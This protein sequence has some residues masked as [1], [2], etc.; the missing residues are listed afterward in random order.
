M[1]DVLFFSDQAPVAWV[2]TN[3]E[4][5]GTIEPVYVSSDYQNGY[6][7]MDPYRVY[8]LSFDGR[9]REILQAGR[10]FRFMKWEG[11]QLLDITTDNP[12]DRSEPS[13]VNTR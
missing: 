2:I 4:G 5:P 6:M 12:E 11:D 9:R 8:P 3:P 7:N 13:G 1:P 10:P